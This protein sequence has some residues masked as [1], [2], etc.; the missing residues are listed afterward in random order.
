MKKQEYF[1][2]L[3]NDASH[4]HSIFSNYI[5]PGKLGKFFDLEKNSLLKSLEEEGKCNA[6][7]LKK[8]SN[9]EYTL[10]PEVKY[11]VN[12]YTVGTD[13]QEIIKLLSTNV[14]S[15][16]LI[17]KEGIIH[18]LAPDN[19]K[20]WHAGKGQ[21]VAN[22][23]LNKESVVNTDKM[24]DFS[25]GI[26]NLNSGNE[27]FTEDQIQSNCKYIANKISL[28]DISPENI[29]GHN[30][31]TLKKMDPGPFWYPIRMGLAYE[32]EKYDLEKPAILC[33]SKEKNDEF[34]TNHKNCDPIKIEGEDIS[35]LQDK[36][37][38]FGFVIPTN[39][40]GK[41]GPMTNKALAIFNM[42]YTPQY[43][44]KNFMHLN[45]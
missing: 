11:I 4:Q 5:P 9:D 20:T 34:V 35:Q 42:S 32:Y 6:F 8:D 45:E 30:E 24:N 12:H 29:I 3:R 26:E 40:S 44:N 10:T 1:D 2:T 23:K 39:E 22:S 18:Q 27:Q 37:T 43:H 21:L 7:S 36:L 16:V 31:W 19:I 17:D 25:I 14:S 41:L 13:L 38:E 15:H 28:H 33:I